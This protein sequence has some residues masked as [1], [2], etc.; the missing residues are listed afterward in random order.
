MSANPPAPEGRLADL[1][2]AT[3]ERLAQAVIDT[4]AAFVALPAGTARNE[5][6]DRHAEAE[7]A[8]FAFV[9]ED[10]FGPE[11]ITA[12]IAAARAGA[13]DTE[14]LR[15]IDENAGAEL[16][17]DRDGDDVR[18]QRWR[19]KYVTYQHWF[20]RDMR[21]ALRAARAALPTPTGGA[22]DA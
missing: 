4:R 11:R 22:A 9:G 16:R 14:L 19:T 13:E 20:G 10:V 8:Y 21:E 5:A 15:W 18:V 2:D 3:L 12:L 1:D 6:F 17:I 7:R